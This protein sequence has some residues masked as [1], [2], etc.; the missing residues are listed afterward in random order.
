YVFL[1]H[2]YNKTP[3][4]FK[5]SNKFKF[6][7]VYQVSVFKKEGKFFICVTYDRQVKDYVDNKKYQAFDLGIMKHTGVNLDGKFIELK[8]SRVDKYWQ[9]RVQE[10]Q[11]RKD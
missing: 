3:L 2:K 9:K 7:K 5:I 4:K 6:G 11:S 1:S 8:N 10:I